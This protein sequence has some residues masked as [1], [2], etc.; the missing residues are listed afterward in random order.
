MV[1]KTALPMRWLAV[2]GWLAG[3]W[4]TGLVG[5]QQNDGGSGGPYERLTIRGA[6]IV[7]GTGAPPEGP[8]DIVVEGSRIVS[9]GP[10]RVDAPTAGRGER[11]ID[12][13]GRWVLPGFVDLHAHI[14][15][16]PPEEYIYKLWL[17]HGITSARD[18]A[19]HRGI[20]FC[21]EQKALSA[22]NRI[23]A[24][25]L[26]PYVHSNLDFAGACCGY[27]WDDG[28]VIRTPEDAREYVRWL[29]KQGV[30]G[31][32]SY[33]QPP[34]VFAALVDEAKQHELGVTVH[35]GQRM[36]ARLNAVDAA[37]AG[38]VT[39]EHWYGTPE[40]L[41]EGSSLVDYRP[42]YNFN[43]EIDR[44]EAWGASWMAGAEPGS[45]TCWRPASRST[46]RSPSPR[47]CATSSAH[48]TSLGSRST[49][50]RR[51]FSAFAP[52]RTCTAA[53][54][55]S[56]RPSTKAFSFAPTRAGNGSSRTTRTAAAG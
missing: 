42:A 1:Q 28:R 3:G 36:L 23:V 13:R 18:A 54:C 29:S 26:F 19:C 34:D 39:L 31:V 2:L 25:R 17:A 35:I 43:D 45:T 55:T 8:V 33:G 22:A 30:D 24:P 7:D 21:V 15:P 40:A 4:L 27:D 16:E 38:V 49:A 11:V 52:T 51:C 53:S 41:L 50:I 47:A 56:G 6:M 10:S 12:G 5:A 20:E 9:V 48:R 32:K 46:R 14:R 44:F 37:R